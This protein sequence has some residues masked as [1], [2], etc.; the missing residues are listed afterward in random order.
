MFGKKEILLTL[1]SNAA[2]P[3]PEA[4]AV[5]AIPTKWPDPILLA[6]SDAPSCNFFRKIM[7][8]FI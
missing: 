2:I 7:L 4:A 6:N 5:P 1:N 8:H 3:I